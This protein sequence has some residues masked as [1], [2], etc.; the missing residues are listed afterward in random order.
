MSHGPV[1]SIL[2]LQLSFDQTYNLEAVGSNIFQL[3]N[4]LCKK[5]QKT[6]R[7]YQIIRKLP[8]AKRYKHLLMLIDMTYDMAHAGASCKREP[9]IAYQRSNVTPLISNLWLVNFQSTKK[10]YCF[11]LQRL[12]CLNGLVVPL[13]VYYV[14]CTS[15]EC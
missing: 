7:V 4:M 14:P 12:W 1:L 10:R 15:Q 3:S 6:A 13:N 8:Q 2:S 9:E 11:C 5:V